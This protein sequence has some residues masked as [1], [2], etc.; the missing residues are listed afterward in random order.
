MGKKKPEPFSEVTRTLLKIAM[1]Q[2]LEP[3][4]PAREGMDEGKLEELKESMA[5]MGL[6]SPILVCEREGVYEIVAGHRRYLAARALGWKEIQAIL[7]DNP[8]AAKEAAMLHE[9]VVREDLNP[10]EEAIFIAQLIDK[11]NL[12]E[13]GICKMMCKGANYIAD[14]LRLLRG[15]PEVLLALRQGKITFASARE[16]NKFDDEVMRRYYLDAAIRS[17]CAS[18]VVTDWLNQWRASKVTVAEQPP[19]A[20]AANES[21]AI[22]PYRMHC[23]FCGGDKDPYNLVNI[24]VHR[25]ELEEIKKVLARGAEIVDENDKR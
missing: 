20:A 19:V 15:D 3:E 13:A 14:R 18:R 5:A 21:A 24:N 23:E 17:G 16:L 8:A 11:Y 1:D 25:W 4:L 2:V 6:L 7:F 9:N 10:G 12:D 22:E